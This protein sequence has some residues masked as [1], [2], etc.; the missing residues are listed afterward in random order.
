[1]VE[2]EAAFGRGVALTRLEGLAWDEEV[3]VKS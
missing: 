1:M 3:A 2:L